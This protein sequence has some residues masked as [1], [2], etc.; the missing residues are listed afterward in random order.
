M[1]RD[2]RF[3]LRPKRGPSKL[4][5][6][7]A[8][9]DV[10]AEVTSFYRVTLRAIIFP[11]FFILQFRSMFVGKATY[12]NEIT[13]QPRSP[14][15]RTIFKALLVKNRF[16]AKACKFAVRVIGELALSSVQCGEIDFLDMLML[17]E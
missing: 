6:A 7:L 15:E 9:V 5:R 10:L 2:D 17:A 3:N 13:P 12:G 16:Y 4:E 14:T 1:H 11:S 8:A